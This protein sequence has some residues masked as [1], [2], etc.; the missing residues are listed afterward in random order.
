MAI[1]NEGHKP[2]L[3][4]LRW[5]MLVS[6]TECKYLLC[7]LGNDYCRWFPNPDPDTKETPAGLLNKK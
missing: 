5:L 4:V 1:A 3:E 2:D 7:F 6:C